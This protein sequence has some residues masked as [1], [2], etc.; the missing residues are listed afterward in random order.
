MLSSITDSFPLV[1]CRF[2]PFVRLDPGYSRSRYHESTSMLKSSHRPTAIGRPFRQVRA[3]E[4]RTQKWGE[5][6]A[7]SCTR[8][9]T[10]HIRSW[11]YSQTYMVCHLGFLAVPNTVRK[12]KGRKKVSLHYLSC[13]CIK[14]EDE[15]ST[16]QYN[17]QGEKDQTKTIEETNSKN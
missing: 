12:A 8:R 1:P 15:S 10:C 9:I 14:T 2:P 13:G 17:L 4:S 16:K 11:I 5:T 3:E 7:F 6:R